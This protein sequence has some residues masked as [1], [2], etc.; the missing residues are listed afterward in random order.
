M[1]A[2][3][4]TPLTKLP[5]LPMPESDEMGIKMESTGTGHSLNEGETPS[6]S[7]SPPPL[8]HTGSGGS[9]KKPKIVIKGDSTQQ[10]GTGPKK[11]KSKPKTPRPSMQHSLSNDSLASMSTQGGTDVEMGSHTPVAGAKGPRKSKLAQEIR[12]EEA[13]LE[14]GSAE[15]PS[16]D[17]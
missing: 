14:V 2:K 1:K 6:I 7:G 12:P 11:T 4:T 3:P 8:V 15:S 17:M 9:H 16:I 13:D 10:S 5:L